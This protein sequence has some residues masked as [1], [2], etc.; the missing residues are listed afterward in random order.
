MPYFKACF[1]PVHFIKGVLILS[2]NLKKSQEYGLLF[3]SKS[4]NLIEFFFFGLRFSPRCFVTSYNIYLLPAWAS[5]T[6]SSA[7]IPCF[8]SYS[9]STSFL[10]L[11]QA[12]TPVIT[13]ERSQSMIL[14]HSGMTSYLHYLS[15]TPVWK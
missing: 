6:L 1:A 12:L 4:S 14:V 11:S 2:A 7:L 5:N 10:C 3:L 15:T 8:S 13:T 9:A